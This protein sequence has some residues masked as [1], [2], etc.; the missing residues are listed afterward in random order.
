MAIVIDD[1]GYSLKHCQELLKI[2]APLNFAVIPGLRS[3][4]SCALAIKKHG[5]E[6]LVH[7]PWEYLGEND[8]KHY[9][10]HLTRKMSRQEMAEMLNKA[11][12]SVPESDG[13]NNH[14]GSQFS[15]DAVAVGTFMELFSKFKNAKYFLDSNTSRATKGYQYAKKYGIKTAINNVFLDGQ[16]AAAYLEQQFLQAINYARKNGTVIAICHVNR[17]TTRDELGK[18]MT[19]YKEHVNYVHLSQIIEIREG[20]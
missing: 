1:A 19:K 8:L 5:Q 3:S 4:K 17:K 12:A 10:V 7:F 6:L 11:F 15:A 16:P 9:P 13:I 14:M 20:I 18:L 2:N